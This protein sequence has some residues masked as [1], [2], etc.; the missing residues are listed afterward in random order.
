MLVDSRLHVH[1]SPGRQRGL[2]QL[3]SA[4]ASDLSQKTSAIVTQ[5]TSST[6]P[7][8][9]DGRHT[10][11]CSPSG[12]TLLCEQPW[13]A[14]S[15]LM[16]TAV[17][18]TGRNR[19]EHSRGQLQQRISHRQKR[20]HQYHNRPWFSWQATVTVARLRSTPTGRVEM[21]SVDD[22]TNP[23]RGLAGWQGEMPCHPE[24]EEHGGARHQLPLIRPE[25]RGTGARPATPARDQ[26]W[27]TRSQIAADSGKKFR[28]RDRPPRKKGK[29]PLPSV[30]A[31]LL[32]RLRIVWRR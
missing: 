19:R 3:A 4:V 31:D 1:R 7:T 10:T 26:D 2:R 30:R 12:M 22:L 14:R 13:P 11:A 6:A 16:S 21:P 23:S 20:I 24:K 28:T 29:E 15:A 8:I 9:A 18:V 25:S 32:C 17:I 27:R 5:R